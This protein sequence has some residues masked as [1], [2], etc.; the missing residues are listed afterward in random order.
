[1]KKLI[2]HQLIFALSFFLLHTANAQTDS[3]AAL[4]EIKM[5]QHEL[6]K[7]YRDPAKS[8]LGKKANQFQ[9]HEFFPINLKFRVVAK[10]KMTSNSPFFMMKTTSVRLDEERVYGILE[11]T[12]EGKQFQLPVY[13][14]SNLLKT[15]E[16]K[17][18][19]FLPFTDLTNGFETYHGG[20]YIDLRIPKGDEI[21]VDFNKAYN[22]YC[23]YASGF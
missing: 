22:P 16:Y 11:F 4:N 18:Y 7:E 9:G 2:Q 23:A 21:I 19:L 20:R 1:M 13:Q 17:D 12:L 10:L 15:Q 3:I 14:S 6:A 8:P 5:F